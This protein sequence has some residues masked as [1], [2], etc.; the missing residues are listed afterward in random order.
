[1]IRV[2]YCSLN[3]T[4]PDDPVI[5]AAMAV[6]GRA[7]AELHSRIKAGA[8]YSEKAHGAAVFVPQGRI[9]PSWKNYVQIIEDL[10]E[11]DL[12]SPAPRR[13]ILSAVRRVLGAD[14]ESG[15]GVLPVSALR[16]YAGWGRSAAKYFAET[17]A[18]WFKSE[19]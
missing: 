16:F 8:A 9:R 1:M 19:V 6:P 2:S 4:G 12:Q 15:Y 17:P 11:V 3:R 5:E 10:D 13:R 14:A 7:I 18:G